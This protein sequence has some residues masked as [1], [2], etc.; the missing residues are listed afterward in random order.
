MCDFIIVLLCLQ[1]QMNFNN[2]Q[3][4]WPGEQPAP[5]NLK[6]KDKKKKDKKDKKSKDSKWILHEQLMELCLIDCNN[7][8][9]IEKRKDGMQL[10]PGSLDPRHVGGMQ[11]IVHLGDPLAQQSKFNVEVQQKVIVKKH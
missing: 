8:D 11:N 10:I 3:S 4:R 2:P 1:Q 6:R 7:F 5:I 9:T